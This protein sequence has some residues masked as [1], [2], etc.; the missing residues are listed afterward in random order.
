MECHQRVC[1]SVAAICSRF[2]NAVWQ[3]GHDE[4]LAP[5]QLEALFLATPPATPPF[6]PQ[7]SPTGEP[8]IVCLWKRKS[9]VCLCMTMC[10]HGTVVARWCLIQRKRGECSWS[11]A[12][13][14]PVITTLKHDYPIPTL[15]PPS[16]PPTTTTTHTHPL[17]EFGCNLGR[18]ATL[19]TRISLPT[20]PPCHCRHSLVTP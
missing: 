6:A 9:G 4:S 2:S 19:N 14:R 11:G 20:S 18:I 13:C 15:P 5:R 10:V 7:S 12:A 16:P 17:C 1:S 3:L 8:L